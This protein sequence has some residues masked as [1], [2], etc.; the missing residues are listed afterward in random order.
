MVALEAAVAVERSE[1]QQ[2]LV[3]TAVRAEAV[4][5]EEAAARTAVLAAH[6]AQAGTVACSW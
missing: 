3:E 5:E 4:A 6:Q 1:P 2:V